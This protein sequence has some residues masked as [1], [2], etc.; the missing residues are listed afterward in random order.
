MLSGAGRVLS[1]SPSQ[2]NVSVQIA[3]GGKW[4]VTIATLTAGIGGERTQQFFAATDSGI[5]FAEG[6]SGLV[7]RQ[8]DL[9]SLIAEY[10]SDDGWRPACP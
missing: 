10:M 6:N 4:D 8:P 7:R 3:P 1:Q 5:Y 9:P 2:V